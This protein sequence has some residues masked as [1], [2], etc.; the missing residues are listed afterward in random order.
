MKTTSRALLVAALLALIVAPLTAQQTVQD[1]LNKLAPEIE[2]LKMISSTVA[3]DLAALKALINPPVSTASTAAFLRVDTTTQG[4]WQGVYGNQQAALA[5]TAPTNPISMSGQSPFIWNPNTSDVRALQSGTARVAACWYGAAFA[6]QID[7]TTPR[8]LAIYLLDWDG[9]G[10]SQR[11]DVLDATTQYV[12]D[13]RTLDHFHDGQYVVWNVTGH[14]VVKVTLLGGVNAVVSGVF[15]DPVNGTPP[16]APLPIP[17]PPPPS[18]PP[19]PL[20]P[21]DPTQ[22]TGNGP[23]A[24]DWQVWNAPQVIEVQKSAGKEMTDL[25]WAHLHHM[26][27]ASQTVTLTPVIWQPNPSGYDANPAGWTPPADVRMRYL[28]HGQPVSEWL[29][30][31]FTFV[32]SINNPL[33]PLFDG[34]WDISMDVQGAS[35][36]DYRARPAYL[37]LHRMRALTAWT[38][39][40]NRD[41]S[42]TDFGKGV[43]YVKRDDLKPKA[44]P[45]NPVV[46]PWSEVPVNQGLWLEWLTVG[47]GFHVPTFMVWEEPPGTP[48]AGLTFVRAMQ[49]AQA[50]EGDFRALYSNNLDHDAFGDDGERKNP[51]KDGPRGVGW[52]NGYNQMQCGPGGNCYFVANAGPLRVVKPDGEL[53]TIAGWRVKP[54]KNPVWHLK[55]LNDVRK[56]MEL[57]GVWLSGQDANDP[58]FHNPGD[59]TVD[60]SSDTP[61]AVTLYVA[62][63]TDNVVWKVVVDKT[64]WVGTVSVFAGA[65]DRSP[66]YV[67]GVGP[68]ARFAYPQSLVHDPVCACLYVADLFNNAVRKIT[69]GGTVTTLFG[70]PGMGARL[71]A[72][73]ATHVFEEFGAPQNHD[74]AENRRLSRFVVPSN[75]DVY[76]PFVIRTNSLGQIVLADNGYSAIRQIDPASGATTFIHDIGGPGVASNFVG[77]W[78]AMDVDRWGHA[79]PL[80]GIYWLTAE[81]TTYTDMAGSR[82]NE[83]FAWTSS[84]GSRSEW[85]FG[86]IGYA[87]GIGRQEWVRP[88]HYAWTVAVD[89]R[90]AVIYGGFGNAGFARLRKARPGAPTAPPDLHQWWNATAIWT[91]GT[92]ED[93]YIQPPLPAFPATSYTFKH[94]EMGH[95]L[96]GFPDSWDYATATDAQIADAFGLAPEIRANAAALASVTAVIR[97]WGAP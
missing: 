80:D 86:P 22:D 2:T 91:R 37:H 34:G 26:D 66:G 44:H 92:Q 5:A 35:R 57:R 58:G 53:V 77:G 33:L 25:A 79:G 71:Q 51:T 45:A 84:D 52:V 93:S 18:P 30:S 60:W 61:T 97:L 11:I 81:S 75:P 56:N 82:F 7:A 15:L 14:V 69:M 54:D 40:F 19:S 29:P 64:T 78:I 94:G 87:T 38:P 31:P 62:G 63:A 42:I 59:V 6:V 41:A 4:S 9:S 20:P 43:V 76:L 13:T 55:P 46:E 73:G 17:P 85:V 72:A 21:P 68:A 67:N 1:L 39:I 95:G 47:G 16:P 83:A 88:P 90:G 23:R 36:L 32:L 96:L 12:L 50:H 24:D 10:R 48:S 70:S 27:P 28:V 49:P 74:T 3:A 65:L 89:S 8:Q